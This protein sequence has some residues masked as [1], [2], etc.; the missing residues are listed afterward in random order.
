MIANNLKQTIDYH[1]NLV[2]LLDIC[3]DSNCYPDLLLSHAS[4]HQLIWECPLGTDKHI[5]SICYV[6]TCRHCRSRKIGSRLRSSA[7]WSGYLLP[8]L[9]LSCIKLSLEDGALAHRPGL[10]GSRFFSAL[11][12]PY[13]LLPKC[14]PSHLEPMPYCER[15]SIL[16]C[17]RLALL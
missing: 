17:R 2:C 11:T 12:Y 1:I 8:I 6:L 13:S 7:C 3:C 14:T 4:A 16:S 9:S 5:S 10:N 15:S